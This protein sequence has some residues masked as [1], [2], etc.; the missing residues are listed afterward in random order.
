MK[1]IIVGF[2]KPTKKKCGAELIKWWLKEDYSHVILSWTDDQNRDIVWHAAHGST[3]LMLL[4]NFNKVN[5]LVKTYKL[6]LT[7]EEYNKL[8]DFCY[9]YAGTPYAFM[10]LLHIVIYDICKNNNINFIP[11]N[12]NG[13]ICSEYISLALKEAKG[14]TIPKPSHLMTPKDVDILLKEV[15]NA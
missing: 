9:Q 14:L 3:H 13:F 2:S 15:L 6:D 7:T 10:D 4:E 8:R 1:Q 11:E 5:N 12:E